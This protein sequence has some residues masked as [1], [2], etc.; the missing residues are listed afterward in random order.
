MT[1]RIF[2]VV[3]LLLL[4]VILWAQDSGVVREIV[5]RGNKAVTA[6][7][8]L[9]NMRTRVN[10]PFVQAELRQDEEAVLAMGFFQD[11]KVLSR[12]L[13]ANE[14]QIIVEVVENPTVKEIRVTGN[15]VISTEQIL[16]LV[17]QQVGQIYNLRN[18][19]PTAE[20]ISRLY[21]EKGYFAEVDIRPL[22][23]APE[24]LNVLVIERAIRDIYIQG[25]TRTRESVVR[26]LIRTKPNEALN[27]IK[28]DADRRR[29]ESTQFFETVGMRARPTDDLGKFDLLIDVKEMKTALIGFGAT[30]VP[31]GGLVGYVRLDD[32]NFRG[33]GQRIGVQLGQDASGTGLSGSLEF[34]NPYLDDRGSA[35]SASVYSRVIT[36]F[37]GNAFG[38]GDAPEDQRFDE[39]RTGF[40]GS[41]TRPL[42]DRLSYQVGARFEA[43]RTINLRT[44]GEFDFIQQ[45]GDL[46]LLNLGLIRD[47][48][49]VPLDPAEGDFARLLVEPGLA[50]ITKVG[51][52]VGDV[53]DVLGQNFFV[54]NTIEYRTYFSRRPA[55]GTQPKLGRRVIALRGRYGTISGQVPFFEQLFIGGAESLRGYS[56]QR[57]WGRNALL[58][59][60]E[61]RAPVVRELTLAGFVDYGGAWGGYS[62][63]N[64]F[65]QSNRP[66]LKLGYGVG[67]LARTP[68]GPIRVDFAWNGEGGS[69]THFTIG[70]SF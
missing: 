21:Q 49:D 64:N 66:N 53:T 70:G 57:F 37:S 17:T 14:W 36:N 6:E 68:I 45:D 15:T 34:A 48:R 51:G 3:P 58:L 4:A 20:A 40:Q 1:K 18:A 27:E 28:L 8:I 65:S 22:E 24:T 62:G 13:T 33:Q 44:T 43:I 16:P 11:V 69:R 2:S 5:V 47:T 56:E 35:F 30:L 19:R 54:R 55:P 50:N 41:L 7:A 61:Y 46:T 31:R 39:R 59:S 63:I 12:A 52:N 38:S 9:A 23:D 42:N 32:T 26:K 60:A 25:L 67:V 29:L 10:A